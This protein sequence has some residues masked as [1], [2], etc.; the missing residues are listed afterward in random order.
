MD[1]VYIGDYDF[2]DG[3]TSAA[4]S[5]VKSLGEIKRFNSVYLES[6]VH[7]ISFRNRYIWNNNKNNAILLQ[8]IFLE[9]LDAAPVFSEITSNIPEKLAVGEMLTAN[10]YANMSDGA[11]YHFGRYKEDGSAETANVMSAVNSN[12]SALGMTGFEYARLG[13][14]DC[15]TAVLTGKSLGSSTISVAATVNCETKSRDFY[16]QVTNEKL[17]SVEAYIE[18]SVVFAGIRKNHSR[19]LS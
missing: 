16:V 4:G 5:I 17:G 18:E 15:S 6:G 8:K 7:S 14:S 2:W 12:N 9:H 13:V 11:P 10:I 3:D 1:D 19:K